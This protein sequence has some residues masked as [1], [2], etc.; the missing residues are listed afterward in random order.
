MRTTRAALRAQDTEIDA[1]NTPATPTKERVPLGDISANAVA[2]A[3]EGT[4][5]ELEAKNMPVK[6]GKGKGGA[7]KAAKGKKAKVAEGEIEVLE[8]ERQA[9]GSPASD[10]AVDELAKGP[11]HGACSECWGSMRQIGQLIVGCRCCSGAH[12]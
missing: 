7:K 2:E 6:K 5:P 1:S 3:V 12:E 4:D 9:A 10:V 11:S 8:D